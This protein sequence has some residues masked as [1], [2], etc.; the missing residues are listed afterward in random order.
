[1]SFFS[2]R[3]TGKIALLFTF[4]PN[5]VET[6]EV[7]KTYSPIKDKEWFCSILKCKIDLGKL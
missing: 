1:M 2:E 6:R 3:D 5:K 4:L 7:L